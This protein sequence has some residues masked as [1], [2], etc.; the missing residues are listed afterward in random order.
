MSAFKIKLKLK[1][2]AY[3]SQGVKE[4]NRKISTAGYKNPNS[5]V[6]ESIV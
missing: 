6:G 2:V 1:S 4:L 5:I 3:S